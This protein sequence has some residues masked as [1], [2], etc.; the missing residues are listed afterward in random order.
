MGVI[1]IAVNFLG[2]DPVRF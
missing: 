1:S 2:G